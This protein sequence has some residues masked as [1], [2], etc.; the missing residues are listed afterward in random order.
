M[1]EIA[2]EVGIEAASLYNHIDSK[3][4]LL[5]A[6]CF[7]IAD[8]FTTEID[9]VAESDSSA[10]KKIERILSFHIDLALEDSKAMT[11]FNQE[12]R[13]LSGPKRKSLQ[14]LRHT[15]E[16]EIQQIIISGQNAGD[17][18]PSLDPETIVK[19]LLSSV[20]WVYFLKPSS[21]KESTA[22][23]KKNINQLISTGITVRGDH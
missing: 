17:I 11:V 18:N 8:R 9:I 1:R 6:M 16:E 10:I 22:R 23:I 7:Q 3:A 2:S 19:L 12:W 4:Q 5:E 13:H 15:Y 21:I 14:D 20:H